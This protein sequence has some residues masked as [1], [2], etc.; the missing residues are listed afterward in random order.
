MKLN[1]CIPWRRNYS[2]AIILRNYLNRRSK[3]KLLNESNFMKISDEKQWNIYEFLWFF[4]Q[5]VQTYET[6]CTEAAYPSV[7]A[8]TTK[9][10]KSSFTNERSVYDFQKL[11]F[12]PNEPYFMKISLQ[13]SVKCLWTFHNYELRNSMKLYSELPCFVPEI[14]VFY[15]FILSVSVS[16]NVQIYTW[17]IN[18]ALSK[19]IWWKSEIKNW[20]SW[21]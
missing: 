11:I 1:N 7:G 21:K 16:E 20:K 10:T 13:Q 17:I 18:C 5:V 9:A 12:S 2:N 3:K 14:T 6:W 19:S 15:C 8:K 4:Y